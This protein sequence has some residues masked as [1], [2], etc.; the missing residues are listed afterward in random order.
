[1]AKAFKTLPL[2]LLAIGV[3]TVPYGRGQSP[4]P[5][6][7]PAPPGGQPAPKPPQ[8]GVQPQKPEPEGEPVILAQPK[9][10]QVKAPATATFSV[11]ARGNPAPAYQW[12]LNGTPIS[13]ATR[14][15]YTTGP[16]TMAN[17]G[18]TY[19]VTVSNGVGN[20]VTSDPAILNVNPPM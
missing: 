9:N 19:T 6:P 16:T 17:D 20:P 1:M 7:Q 5:G 15:S 11:T 14:S 3:L 2:W 4:Q 8:P 12:N 18:E 13:G 10:Q